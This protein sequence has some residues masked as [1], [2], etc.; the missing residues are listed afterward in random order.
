MLKELVSRSSVVLPSTAA[1]WDDAGLL[2][3]R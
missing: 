3:T 1:A 2:R